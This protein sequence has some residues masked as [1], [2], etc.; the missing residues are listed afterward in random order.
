[1]GADPP[2]TAHGTG[3]AGR[4]ADRAA[5]RLLRLLREGASGA[6]YEEL[7]AGAQ[8]ET[9]EALRPLVDD[10]LAVRAQLE[11]RRRREA[12]LAA[13]YE[14]AGDLSSLRDLEAVLQAIVRRVRQLIGTDAAYLML[15]DDDRGDTY[16]RVTDGIRTDAFKQVRLAM[17]A[18]LGGLVAKTGVPYHTPDYLN[19]P[20]FDHTIDATVGGEGVTAIQG[21][22]LSLGDRVIGV[23][24]AANR[25]ARPFSPAEVALLV[26]LANH[27]AIA[28]ENATLFQDVRRT[29]DELTEAN[30]L[31]Q[32]HSES[33]E[34]AAALHERLTRI[35]LDGGGLADVADTLAEVLGGGLLVLDPRGRTMAAAGADPVVEQARA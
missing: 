26:S 11:D 1:M 29:V 13:L 34:R 35:V 16:M 24:F 10:A 15:N 32:A 2:R 17:G 19:D 33:I 7:L 9:A 8:G 22:P 12:E 23:L 20:R 30:A 18:G 21:V 27:A 3:P 31:I 14:T 28:I 4:A 5:E 25:R 6:D